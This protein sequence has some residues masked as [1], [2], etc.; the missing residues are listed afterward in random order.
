M[1][2]RCYFSSS[3]VSTHHAGHLVMENTHE[4]RCHTDRMGGPTADACARSECQAMFNSVSKAEEEFHDEKGITITI[5]D[6]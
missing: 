2:F 4:L 3:G 5:I 1:A 6:G